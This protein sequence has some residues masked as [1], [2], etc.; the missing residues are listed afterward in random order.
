MQCGVGAR[1]QKGPS[2]KSPICRIGFWKLPFQRHL[3]EVFLGNFV[4]SSQKRPTSSEGRG[5]LAPPSGEVPDFCVKSSKSASETVQSALQNGNSAI[6]VRQKTVSSESNLARVSSCPRKYQF[7]GKSC[8]R[9]Q[10]LSEI[11]PS[12]RKVSRRGATMTHGGKPV[13]P[14][15]GRP[16]DMTAKG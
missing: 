8:G 9:N 15:N 1:L 5:F 14:A 4:N 16:H 3:G 6:S 13:R 7:F 10:F 11:T 2:E 12:F